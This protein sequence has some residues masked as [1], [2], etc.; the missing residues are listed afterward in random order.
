MNCYLTHDGYLLQKNLMKE[1][2][3]KKLKKD[4]T[5]SPIV[6]KAYIGFKK[7]PE[8]K[9]YRESANYMMIP[10][11]YGI[12]NYGRP[13][14]TKLSEGLQMNDD[15]KFTY[16]LLPHQLNATKKTLETLT[17][18]NGGILSL[19]CG[20]GKTGISIYL[21]I[22]LGRKTGVIVNKECLADQWIDAINK[23]TAGKARIGRIQQ[24]IYDI[25]D[26]DFVI[27]MV[28]TFVKREFPKTDLDTFG[29]FILDECH[30]MGS[31]MFSQALPKLGCKYLL[32]LSATPTRKDGLSEVFHSYLGDLCHSEKRSSN[33]N[34]LVKK[35]VLKSNSIYYKDLFTSNG[36]KNTAGMTTLL[37]TF[38]TRNHFIIMVIKSLMESEENKICNR[39]ILLLSERREH[40]ESLYK[41]LESH[42]IKTFNHHNKEH[43]D[44]KDKHDHKNKHEHQDKHD[45][46]RPITF[47]YYYGN[48][49]K[50]KKNHKTLLENSSKCDVVLGTHQL[51]SEGLDIPDLNTEII[52]TSRT[53]VEQGVGRI[54]RKYHKIRPLVIDIIDD[55]GNFKA[56]SY[57][58][59]KLYKSENYVINSTN[60]NL[61]QPLDFNLINKQLT[62]INK[63]EKEDEYVDKEDTASN[64]DKDDSDNNQEIKCFI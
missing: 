35:F 33:N 50:N 41:L 40:L 11:F 3:I 7:A 64:E 28:H 5:K 25:K 51:A 58:R 59:N 55:F 52:A 30:H 34:V 37:C 36:T 54:L 49:G 57:S 39:K 44:H 53:D 26:K 47:G 19:P 17:N 15:V 21:A 27:C 16:E 10:R 22:K 4:L 1:E 38:D 20:Y 63:E 46:F 23:F 9:M 61:D 24:E 62:I 12:K 42:K 45:K 2:E 8:I 43:K 13:V 31:E 29:M 32:G 56:Q 14:L 18:K 60:I 48:N 6:L